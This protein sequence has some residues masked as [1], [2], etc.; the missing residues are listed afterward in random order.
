VRVDVV[1]RS[2][3]CGCKVSRDTGN[4]ARSQLYAEHTVW[5]HS[6]VGT[7]G[8][9]RDLI[10]KYRLE[11]SV[12]LELTTYLNKRK[13]I[14]K[15]TFISDLSAV[16]ESFAYSLQVVR[17]SLD[18]FSPPPPSQSWQIKTLEPAVRLELTTYGLQNRCSTN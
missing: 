3:T 7:P 12:K 4:I 14:E 8:K 18:S 13:S 6:E 11:P 5:P 15:F 9:E 1:W 17:K 16:Q 10:N 2:V